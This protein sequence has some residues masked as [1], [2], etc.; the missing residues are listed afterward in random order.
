MGAD[1]VGSRSVCRTV[2]GLRDVAPSAPGSRAIRCGA[3]GGR[4]RPAR[5]VA[6]P[7][8][9]P[10]QRAP[11]NRGIWLEH[12]D[13][14]VKRLCLGAP[15]LSKPRELCSAD[16]RA[17]SPD[18]TWLAAAL[19]QPKH[20]PLGRVDEGIAGGR[21]TIHDDCSANG[22]AFA[23]VPTVAVKCCTVRRKEEH[24]RA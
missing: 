12:L 3:T 8:T 23:Q 20:G 9:S 10:A 24:C 18:P 22:P 13:E 1:V 4:H 11:E 15:S 19:G 7:A 21:M 5:D 2:A 16:T 17:M 14:E 6:L